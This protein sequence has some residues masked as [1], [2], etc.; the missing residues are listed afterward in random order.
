MKKFGH[1]EGEQPYFSLDV[2]LLVIIRAQILVRLVSAI[3]WPYSVIKRIEDYAWKF[4]NNYGMC[5][6]PSTV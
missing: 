3:H 2:L 5:S 4:H 6:L 1:V